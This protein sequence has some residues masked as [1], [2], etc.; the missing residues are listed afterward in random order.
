M[1]RAS[2]SVTS[3]GEE[4]ARQLIRE[5]VAEC[6]AAIEGGDTQLYKKHRLEL[7]EHGR[8][9]RGYAPIGAR[10][11]EVE[12][13]KLEKRAGERSSE[14]AVPAATASDGAAELET[15]PSLTEIPRPGPRKPG[16]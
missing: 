3:T 4:K 8:H 13:A 10:E 9:L 11:V 6:D 14:S 1:K 2:H 12:A 16:L 7:L 5:K 15:G